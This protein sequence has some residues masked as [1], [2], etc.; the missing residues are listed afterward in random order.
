MFTAL[1]YALA[2]I[3]LVASFI[4][5][6]EKTAGALYKAWSAFS[7]ILPEFVMIITASGLILA[8]LSPD[9]IAVLI[10]ERSGAVGVLLASLAG[11][12]TLIPGFVAFPLAALLLEKGAGILQIGAFVSALMMVGVV[13]F[14]LERKTF[15]TR[16]AVTR[17][18][19]AWV[20]S[21]LVALVLRLVLGGAGAG[22]AL[23]GGIG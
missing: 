6:R 8:Y 23:L 17:N 18:V 4:A 19:L 2:A 13:T 7:G 3:G 16:V 15:G 12:V 14:S 1:F 20:F 21:L 5:D 9:V 22:V 10:G 11:S